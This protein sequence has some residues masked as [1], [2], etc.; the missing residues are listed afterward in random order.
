[1]RILVTGATGY[2]GHHISA[3]LRRDG[4][5]VVGLTRDT[6]SV[7]ARRLARVEVQPV[8]GD[9][10][11]PEGYRSLL[12]DVDLVVHTTIDYRNPVDSDR[13][14]FRELRDAAD[15]TG[16]HRHLV[17]TT[18]STVYGK[19]D[20]PLLDEA[21]PGNPDHALHFRLQLEKELAASGLP[22]T[23]IRPAFMYGGADASTSKTGIW[24]TDAAQGRAVFYG[25]QAKSWSWVHVDDLAEAYVLVVARATEL[26]GEVFCIADEQRL[27]ALDTLR[28]CHRRARYDGQI[29]FRPAVDGPWFDQVSDQDEVMTAAKA[30]RQLGW[31]PRHTGVLDDL[32]IYYRTWRHSMTDGGVLGSQLVDEHA[33]A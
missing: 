26:D 8:Q 16:R 14:L 28:A 11:D 32:D 33:L 18:G 19:V 25:D 1:M 30:R 15:R 4:H 13:A 12:D 7:R 29:E 17:Y 20:A 23:V 21:T 10:A 24:F 22:H 3:A 2:A 6:A 31:V 9:I 27:T 5:R